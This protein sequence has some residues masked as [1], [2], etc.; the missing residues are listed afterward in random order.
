M[1][2]LLI[3][4]LLLELAGSSPVLSRE[5]LSGPI[6]AEL[7]RVVDGD[8]LA[9]RALIWPGQ[10][11]D[12]KVRLADIDAPELYRPS[13]TRERDRARAARNFL[14]QRTGNTVTLR[15]VHLGKYAGRV[16][17]RVQTDKGEDLSILLLQAGLARPMHDR[18]GWCSKDS[19]GQG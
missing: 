1:K 7:V 13:C 9:V 10:H 15:A 3:P 14:V 19:E 12:I 18:T 5:T 16:V 4:L 6:A 2:S 17:A 11:I 8:T